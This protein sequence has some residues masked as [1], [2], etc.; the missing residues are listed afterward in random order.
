MLKIFKSKQGYGSI[1]AIVIALVLLLMFN[2]VMEY[3]RLYTISQG[4]KEAAQ[5]SINTLATQNTDKAYSF[6]R[7]GQNNLDYDEEADARIQ[8][9]PYLLQD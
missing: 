3:F 6:L 9:F 4:V 2:I 5:E 8:Y 1:T 7:E